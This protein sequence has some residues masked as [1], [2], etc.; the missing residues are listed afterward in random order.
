MNDQDF[1]NINDIKRLLKYIDKGKFDIKAWSSAL[2]LLESLN[3][4]TS[5]HEVYMD[6]MKYHH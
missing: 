5:E 4:L 3:L 2:E 1:E 6:H